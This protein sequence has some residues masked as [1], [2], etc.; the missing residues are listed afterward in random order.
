M[1]CWITSR[2]PRIRSA[3]KNA[4][5]LRGFKDEAEPTWEYYLKKTTAVSRIV[6][7][8]NTFPSFLAKGA[9]RAQNML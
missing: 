6:A 3:P 7:L 9:K 8:R 5:E 1:S 4:E 2:V